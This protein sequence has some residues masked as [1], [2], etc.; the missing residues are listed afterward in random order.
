MLAMGSEMSN[1]GYILCTK[2][3]QWSA[4]KYY[5]PEGPMYNNARGPYIPFCTFG[6]SV[7]TCSK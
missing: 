2:D 5:E 4:L 6:D 3:T 1:K 7:V